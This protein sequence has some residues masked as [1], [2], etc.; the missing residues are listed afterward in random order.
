MI[1]KSHPRYKSLLLREKVVNGF[2]EGYVVPQGLIAHGRGE[3]FDYL[4]GEDSF[5]FALEAEKY[6]VKLL[7]EAKNPVISVNGNVAA[8]CPE[9]VVK[10]SELTGAKIEINLFYRT[11]ERVKKI[12]E[13]FKKL[14]KDVLGDV[15][16]A[17]IPGLEHAR[18]LCTKDGIFSA[19]VILL[20]LEDGDRTE[21]LKKMGKTVIAIDLNPLS[22]TA[23]TADVTIVDEV[24][25]AM[26]NMI[27]FAE[28]MGRGKLD[29][30]G[31]FNNREILARSIIHI[32]KRLK[33]IA[34]G[35]LA[36]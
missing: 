11:E 4:L 24:T 15:P 5:D 23:R 14:G 7:M 10:L 1:P 8:L 27:K 13:I 30:R 12:K 28:D 6:A 17:K 16:D 36:Q 21:A 31:K 18:A 33:E 19:D 34:D 22:R 35:F 2:E 25:R 20:A 9:E 32:N 3:T 29:Y 26:N